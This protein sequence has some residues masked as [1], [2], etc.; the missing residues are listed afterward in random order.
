MILF[1]KMIELLHEGLIIADYNNGKILS[2]SKSCFNIFRLSNMFETVDNF[3]NWNRF[4]GSTTSFMESDPAS[5]IANLGTYEFVEILK[6]VIDDPIVFSLRNV[7][8]S[9]R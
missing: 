5:V 9:V 4:T 1:Q 8:K 7:A 3:L 6:N 2:M